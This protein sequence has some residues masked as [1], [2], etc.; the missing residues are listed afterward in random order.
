[1][2]GGYGRRRGRGGEVKSCYKRR[3]GKEGVGME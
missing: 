3:D 1:M 2:E